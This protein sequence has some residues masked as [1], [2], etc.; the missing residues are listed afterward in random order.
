VIPDPAG[1]TRR[2]FLRG[3]GGATLALPVL[4]SLLTARE[5]RAQAAQNRRCFVQYIS[6]HGGVY[7]D[8]MFP[9]E[10][11]LTASQLY[12]TAGHQV[13]QGLLPLVVASGVASLSPVLTAPSTELTPALVAKMN[14]LRGLDITYPIAHHYGGATM[15]NLARN[16]SNSGIGA[17]MQQHPRRSIDQ[18]MA[19]APAFYPDL[20]AVRSRSVV[21]VQNTSISFNYSDPADPSSPVGSVGVTW[22]ANSLALFDQLFPNPPGATQPARPPIVDQVLESYKRLRNGDK[23]LSESDKRRLDDHMQRIAELQRR[24]S[25][26]NACGTVTRPS[27]SNESLKGTGYDGDPARH[28]QYFQL[29]NDV[30]V[31]ALHCGVTRIAAL[32]GDAYVNTFSTV[33]SGEWHEGIAHQVDAKQQVMV[34][35]QQRFFAG[36]VLDLARKLDAAQEG[37][38]TTLLDRTLLTWAQEHGNRAHEAFS[39]PVV[40]LGGAD[41]FL[42]TGNYCDYR[43]LAKRYWP[44]ATDESRHI[45]PGLTW[46]QWL[47]SCLQAMGVPRSEYQEPD[48]NGYG[49]RIAATEWFPQDGD[50]AWPQSVWTAAGDVL[51]FLKT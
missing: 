48:H 3:L 24:L 2:F 43:N 14:V 6:Q 31:A 4:P 20:S 41:G 49:K 26:A 10:A 51:P 29:L 35:A 34:A 38:G 37:D 28:V 46:H 23:R 39:L 15:G 9:P 40:T 47:G 1:P 13:R 16:S 45:A 42:K 17:Q 25:V 8:N 7:A 5:A 11:A 18:V 22:M 30:L 12:A 44:N 19:W 32:C 27:T 21:V 33:A 36:V 50:Y